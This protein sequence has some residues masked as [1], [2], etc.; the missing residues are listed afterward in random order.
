MTTLY[1][2]SQWRVTEDVVET[3]N[4][5]P[6]PYFISVK[7]IA[8]TTRAPL[9]GDNVYKWPLHMAEKSW[10]DLSMFWGAFEFAIKHFAADKVNEYK[11]GSTYADAVQVKDM[12][13]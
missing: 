4:D 6:V 10:V 11:L 12:A 5:K 2:N 13:R 7:D 3:V 8:Q 9:S 1:E